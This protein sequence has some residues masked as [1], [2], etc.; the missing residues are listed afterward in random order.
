VSAKTT[1]ARAGLILTVLGALVIVSAVI[2]ANVGTA[3]LTAGEIARVIWNHL[4]GAAHPTANDAI[5]WNLRLPRI[6]LAMLV[7]ASLATA[8]AL[9]QSLFNNPMADPFVVGASSGAA[10]GAVVV[11]SMDVQ[12]T[13]FGLNAMCFAALLGGLGVTLLVY[14]LSR[15]AGRV[16]IATL[17]LTGIA[18]GGIMQ[19]VTTL[20][21]LQRPGSELHEVI[22]WLMGSLA[23]RD[24]P[25]VAALLPY[26]IVG[27]GVAMAYRRDLNVLAL[28]EEAA[29]SLGVN[30]ER[31]KVLLLLTAS[32]LAAASVA[33][34]GIIAFVGLIVPHLMR[35]LVGPNHRFL[36]PACILGGGLILIWAD[37]AARLIIPGGEIPIGIVT[38]VLGSGFFL[39][40]LNRSRGKVV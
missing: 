34:S 5:V 29:H 21:L 27:I 35:L 8:G 38:S 14:T 1:S 20:L 18:I 7:G 23:Y 10:L 33:V 19:A 30:V 39:Y 26:T 31:T 3:H 15:R 6:V 32:L 37:I 24:W 13:L 40:L 17:L 4:A 25:H 9:M 36:L 12:A 11:I 16:P 22:G 28:G 2:S